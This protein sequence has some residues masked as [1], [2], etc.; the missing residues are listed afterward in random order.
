M[1]GVWQ[2]KA[3]CCPALI[4][5]KSKH[6]SQLSCQC[7]VSLFGLE[8]LPIQLASIGK[9]DNRP[10]AYRLYT[11]LGDLSWCFEMILF[12]SQ[13]QKLAR[14]LFSVLLDFPNVFFSAK[15]RYQFCLAIVGRSVCLFYQKGH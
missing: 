8:A 1:H 12:L 10:Y 15:C 6:N 3:A 14:Y 5:I 9:S 13:A 11:R 4:E 2:Y 7:G